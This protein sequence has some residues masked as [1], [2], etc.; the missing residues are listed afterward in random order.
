MFWGSCYWS[1][2]PGCCISI[3]FWRFQCEIFSLSSENS[4]PPSWVLVLVVCI[5]VEKKLRKKV[6]GFGFHFFVGFRYLFVA[7]GNYEKSLLLLP[8][9]K[10]W[11]TLK[12]PLLNLSHS[13]L[14]SSGAIWIW[15][16]RSVFLSS[17]PETHWNSS[18]ICSICKS[19]SFGLKKILQSMFAELDDVWMFLGV[20]FDT[21]PEKIIPQNNQKNH[22]AIRND[23]NSSQLYWRSLFPSS[24]S[25]SRSRDFCHQKFSW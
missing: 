25:S 7:Y 20:S 4:A 9:K 14:R 8:A 12:H 6:E 15:S 5:F 22:T 10:L 13:K 19:S 3:R 21:L 24:C 16:L 1:I 11:I 17:F 23:W 18:S 2:W